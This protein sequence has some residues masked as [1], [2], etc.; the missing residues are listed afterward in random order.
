MLCVHD[1]LQLQ[2]VFKPTI[3][4]APVGQQNNPRPLHRRTSRSTN[5]PE[6]SV[7]LP[8]DSGPPTTL[9]GA[10]R[11]LAR[12]SGAVVVMSASLPCISLKQ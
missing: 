3:T 4:D 12:P 1:F 9:R 6:S 2:K 8:W 5:R 10:A 11:E 7:W